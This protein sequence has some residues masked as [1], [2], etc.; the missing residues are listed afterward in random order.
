M[1]PYAG[2]PIEKELKISNRL[3]GTVLQHDY[4][5]LDPLLDFYFYLVQNIFTHRNFDDDGIINILTNTEFEYQ[6]IRFFY[7]EF[8]IGDFKK[9]LSGLIAKSNLQA[10][11]TLEK[12]LDLVTSKDTSQLL[13]KSDEL[14]EL[15]KTEWE[16]EFEI[17]ADLHDIK[18][19]HL[20]GFKNIIL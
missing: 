13:E 19:K 11:E 17:E 9:T 3:K 10:I 12:V 2:T 4:D 8:P 1:L 6:L 7:P 5:F 15:A 20:S 16:I 18:R 14:L